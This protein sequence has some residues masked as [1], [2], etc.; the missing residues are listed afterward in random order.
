MGAA[1]FALEAGDTGDIEQIDEARGA[2]QPIGLGERLHLD[3][4]DLKVDT[5]ADCLHLDPGLAL[6]AHGQGGQRLRQFE[7]EVVAPQAH[8]ADKNLAVALGTLPRRREL[9]RQFEMKRLFA[10]LIELVQR[11]GLSEFCGEFCRRF[12]GRIRLLQECCQLARRDGAI[13]RPARF[14]ADPQCFPRGIELRLTEAITGDLRP[15]RKRGQ[16]QDV[17]NKPALDIKF[18]RR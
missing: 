15:G 11:A 9:G 13:I 18:H 6:R 2:G 8:C 12:S 14:Y 17:T 7:S 4:R 16:G 3:A 10:R 5:P 1:G